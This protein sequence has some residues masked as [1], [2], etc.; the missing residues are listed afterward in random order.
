MPRAVR[1]LV[2][3]DRVVERGRIEKLRAGRDDRIRARAVEGLRAVVLDARRLGHRLDDALALGDRCEGARG[4][5]VRLDPLALL[6][7]KD[8]VIAE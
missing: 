1:Q 2:K 4:G 7:V 6:D 8:G 5:G 3:E